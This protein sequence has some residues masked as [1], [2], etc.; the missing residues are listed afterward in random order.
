MRIL[1]ISDVY[2][3]RVN[4]VST[5]IRTFR[6][7]L[8][9]LGHEVTLV[10]PAY[11]SAEG[12]DD[13]I[14]RVPSRKVPRDPEDRMMRRNFLDRLFPEL[15]RRRCEIAHIQ[16]PFVA[17]YAGV[18]LAQRLRIPVVES[19]H[20]FF[21]E[22]LHHYVP[23]VPRGLMKLLARRFT[24]SQCKAVDRLISPSSAMKT[25]LC[26]YGVRTKIEI[27]P[28]GLDQAQFREGNGARFRLKHNIPS[29][30]PTLL[31]V[32][33]VAHEKNIGFLLQVFR[34]VLSRIPNA[35][36]VIAGEGPAL[37]SL[38]AQ[39]VELGIVER[40]KFIG[41][42]DR[43]TELL[44]CYRA[45]DLFIF[46][47]RTETQGLVLLEALAQGT[48]VVSTAHM[49]TCDV[50][51][52]ARGARIASDDIAAFAQAVC[53]LLLNDTA[54]ERLALLAPIDASKWSSRA[55]A[56]RLAR[57]YEGAIESRQSPTVDLQRA[58]A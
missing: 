4:G 43:D 18:E 45:G 56:E 6:R 22:Y 38:R 55:F 33:R 2:F 41:Y 16:T 13:D 27:L 9:A 47:S 21:E 58:S 40:L 14:I 54:R 50:L 25:A 5:S 52:H 35:I 32:G 44:D 57:C 26:D 34:E 7:E 42:L 29:T 11:A 46:A 39:A 30:A 19:Y 53:D 20:T 12:D 37:P 1:M 8:I 3:P 23:I 48:P 24:V 15:L 10:V 28:T 17:H 31:Y 36:F 49:G 51:E